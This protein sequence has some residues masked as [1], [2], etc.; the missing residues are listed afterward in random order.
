LQ[1]AINHIAQIVSAHGIREAIICPGSRSAPLTLAFARHPEI[2]CKSIIDE[3]SAGFIALGLAQQLKRTVALICTSGSAGLNFAPAIAEAFYQQV[4]LLVFTADRPPEWINQ[5]DGQT[6][7][8][9]G[10]FGP[11]VLGSYQLPVEHDNEPSQWQ[12]QRMVNEAILLSRGPVAGPVHINV[13]LREP[14]YDE[15]AGFKYNEQVRVIHKENVMPRIEPMQAEKWRARWHAYEKKL[16]VAGAGFPDELLEQGIRHFLPASCSV[17][18]ADI[19][20]NLRQP[21]SIRNW[22]M[23]IAGQD[24]KTLKK[25]QPELLVTFGLATVSKN[26]KL[27]LRKYKPK[28]HWHIQSHGPAADP[29]LSLSEIIPADT[30]D[31]FSSLM[32]EERHKAAIKKHDEYLRD[33]KEAGDKAQQQTSALFTACEVK[34]SFN[35]FLAVKEVLSRLPEKSRLQVANSMP[36]RYVSYLGLSQKHISIHANR[37][38]SGIDGCLSTAVGAALATKEITT[39]ITGDLAF[40]YDRNALWNHVVPANLRIVIMNNEGGGIFR[41]IEGP[42]SLPELEEYFETTHSMNAKKTAEDHGMQYFFCDNNNSLREILPAFFKGGKA[43]ILEIKTDKI[44]NQQFF[45]E[46]RNCINTKK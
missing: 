3:R 18:L 6:I 10:M 9:T 16:V 2:S 38:T 13:P 24:E 7:M 23:V 25:L 40:F 29:F 27:F 1:Q 5:R 28:E 31:F 11:H 34:S 4:P 44:H 46:F 41:L 32:Q 14:L 8:Q 36:V 35:E 21:Q 39:L 33:W 45:S 26:L 20:S 15:K 19:V 30:L 12:L 17:F 22:D 42:S 37:G 43:S